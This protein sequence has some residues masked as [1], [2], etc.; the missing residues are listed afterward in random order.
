M[1]D[2]GQAVIVERDA[3]LFHFNLVLDRG[4]RPKHEAAC[5]GQN[6]GATRTYAVFRDEN[7]EIVEHLVDFGGRGE[8][9]EFHS[10]FMREVFGHPFGRLKMGVTRAEV[11]RFVADRSAAT[12][13]ARIAA[14][15]AS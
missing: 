3:R 10:E 5:I 15:A 6:A 2:Y 7:E 11:G 13:T 14:P 4:Q 9:I 1:V 8:A 12:A